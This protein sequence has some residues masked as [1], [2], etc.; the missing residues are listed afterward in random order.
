MT[1]VQHPEFEEVILSVGDPSEWVAAGWIVVDMS[2][3]DGAENEET[4]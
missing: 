3:V 4:E 2:L 1:K